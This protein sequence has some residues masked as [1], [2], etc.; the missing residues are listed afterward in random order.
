MESH[1]PP[2]SASTRPRVIIVGAGMSGLSAANRITTLAPGRFDLTILEASK[3]VGGRICTST[4]CGERVEMGAT[5]IHGIE[6]SP[7]HGIAERMGSMQGDI[8]WECMDGFPEAPIVMAEGG[9]EVPSRI[10]DSVGVLYKK[11]YSLIQDTDGGLQQFYEGEAE[12]STDKFLQLKEKLKGESVGAYLLEGLKM[13][14]STQEESSSNGYCNGHTAGRKQPSWNAETLQ[15]GVFRMRENLERSVTAAESLYD[16]DLE[17]NDEYWEYP[18]EHKTIGKGYSSVINALAADLPEG[19]IQL[20]KKVKRIAWLNC[21]VPVHIYCE[22]GTMLEADHVIITVSLGVLKAEALGQAKSTQPNKLFQ[23]PLPPWKLN[24]ISKLG[25]GVVDKCFLS[26]KPSLSG[27]IYP[28]MQLVFREEGWHDACDGHGL[29]DIPWWMRRNFS[30]YPIHQASNVLCTWLTGKEALE[31]ESLSNEEVIDGV[32]KTMESFGFKEMINS[33]SHGVNEK[34]SGFASD[35]LDVCFDGGHTLQVQEFLRSRW[36]SNPLF[37]GSYSYV[38][39]GSSGKD[40]DTLAEPL[41]R[42][43]NNGDLIKSPLQLL[44]AGE[45]THRYCYS[46]T[47]GAFLSGVREAERL[48]KHYG[49]LSAD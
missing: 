2:I 12:F 19:I 1:Q 38:A 46:T 7:V 14:L 29:A 15:Q 36:G 39:V 41:P 22:D 48:V 26:M 21:A 43:S 44:F 49:L 10:A 18:G 3:R 6:G 34:A 45:A 5:W 40:I 25:F 33:A 4:F 17:S 8:P 37:R 31:M 24:A 28:H 27:A 23:P 42:P 11:L 30:F 35:V 32:V 13:Y 9:L 20:N 16:L 47:H